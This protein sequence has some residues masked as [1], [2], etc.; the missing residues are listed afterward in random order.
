M[1]FY[2]QEY[3]SASRVILTQLSTYDSSCHYFFTFIIIKIYEMNKRCNLYMK[4]STATSTPNNLSS[5]F[6]FL[7]KKVNLL[8]T[9]LNVA[10]HVEQH[11][12]VSQV[13]LLQQLCTKHMLTSFCLSSSC[14]SITTH[15]GPY[16]T[17]IIVFPCID[18]KT[19]I[20]AIVC[21]CFVRVPIMCLRTVFGMVVSSF[22]GCCWCCCCWWWCCLF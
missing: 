13:E 19:P 17:A 7:R 5:K 20:A 3:S 16:E 10:F 11:L 12:R 21:I 6:W 22:D 18:V 15:D 8:L 4:A 1:S 14:C 9:F 2:I